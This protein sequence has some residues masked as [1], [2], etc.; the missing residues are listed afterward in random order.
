MVGDQ[1]PHR[2]KTGLNQFGELPI[3]TL[4]PK[5]AVVLIRADSSQQMGTGHVMRCLAL[6][7][8]GQDAGCRIVY[9]LASCS[10]GV[11]ERL[12]AE[13]IEI[14]NLAC[15][16][17]SR[18][19]ALA[20]VEAARSCGSNWIVLD[21]YHFDEQYHA[22][23]KQAKLKLLALDDFGALGRYIADIVVNQDP[24]ADEQLY[25]RREPNTR[26][27]LGSDYTFLRR[28]FRLHPRPA[29][30]VP[31]IARR[32]LLTFG[33]SD[34]DRLTE[35]AL[36]ELESVAVDDFEAVVLIGPSNWRA[37]QLEAVGQGRNKI[38]LLRNPPD[39]PEW[40]AWCDLAV[41]AVGGTL[42]ELAYCRVPCIALLV[43]EDQ[44]PATDILQRRGA[45]LSLG[46]GRNLSP[47]CLAQTISTL[48]HD[49]QR[50]AALGSSLAAMVD[51]LGAAARPGSDASRGT[52]F[53]M[54]VAMMQPTFL[55]WLGFFELIYQSERFVLGDDSQYS[56][57]SYHQRNRLFVQAG[58]VG[59]FTVPVQ[60]KSRSAS[61]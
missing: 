52:D 9:A 56:H 11:A 12:L 27:L 59:W 55:P 57:A 25:V 34:P 39:I 31:A 54:K 28:E 48:C 47:G 17:G 8:A 30:K 37:E 22:V 46:I 61:R 45:C 44:V 4:K 6:A 42:W 29:R 5:D 35:M 14:V 58:Q 20:T 32:L 40:M 50:R 7:Q 36:A 21:G 19:D 60:K 1:S 16:P 23:I 18:Q 51:G 15:E 53:T 43:S 38:R 10:A 49:P 26:L 24:I 13:N 33:G 3:S 41:T 2:A